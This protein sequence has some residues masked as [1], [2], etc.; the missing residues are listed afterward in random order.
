[1]KRRKRLEYVT[2]N[3]TTF[4]VDTTGNSITIDN[5]VCMDLTE[6]D[7]TIKNMKDIKEEIKNM[8]MDKRKK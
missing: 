4:A 8:K 2:N 6:I 1:M 3:G 5:N 7:D